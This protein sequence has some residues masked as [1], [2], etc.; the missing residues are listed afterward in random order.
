M[1]PRT[2]GRT[3]KRA[4]EA[5]AA[6][7]DE[8]G[9]KAAK[10]GKTSDVHGS[11]A[12]QPS[13]SD[14]TDPPAKPTKKK[15]ATSN[16]ATKS[17]KSTKKPAGTT[18]N[19]EKLYKAS[20][21][22]IDKKSKELARRMKPNQ[23]MYGVTSD[24]YAIAMA[25]FLP[26]VEKLLVDSPKH[27][28]NL[29]MYIGEQAHAD[30]DFGPKM[31]GFGDTE[32]PYKKMD[33]VMVRVIDKRVEADGKVEATSMEQGIDEGNDSENE[34]KAY[35]KEL[36][37]KRPNKSERNWI[38]KLRQKE[39]ALKI[40]TAKL[41]RETAE[42]WAPIALRDMVVMR[43]YLDEYGIGDH[44]FHDSIAKLEAFKSPAKTVATVA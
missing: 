4:L 1:P 23:G 31:C 19:S 34:L 35:M 5:D 44:Y 40:Q 26:D 25:K 24:H 9:A 7:G 37:G 10:L 43:D 17:T 30:L 42:A 32:E 21:T 33:Q 36:G 29:L 22:A 8:K 3:R 20:I 27:A 13:D 39:A 41:R 28:F 12:S 6:S 18:K 11:F 2:S 38:D 15:T 16:R 14:D